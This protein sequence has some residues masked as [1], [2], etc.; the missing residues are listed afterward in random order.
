VRLPELDLG[1]IDPKPRFS[2]NCQ[3]YQFLRIAVD[4]GGGILH[5]FGTMPLNGSDYDDQ[6]A[7]AGTY[8]IH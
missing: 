3:N 5:P 7:L 8:S 1:L 4:A 6:R 2:P